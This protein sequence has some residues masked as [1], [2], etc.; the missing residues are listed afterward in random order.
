MTPEQLW[1]EFVDKYPSYK[2]KTYDVFAFGDKTD[3]LL[4]LVISGEKT[5]TSCIYR[6]GSTNQ[7]GDIGIILD[8]A[9]NAQ[10]IIEDTKVSIVPFNK[11]NA[12]FARKEGE[13]DKTLATWRKIHKAFWKDMKPDTLLECEE[14]KLLYP[15]K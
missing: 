12:A 6:G 14:F 3:E 10:A 15:T 13:G 11:V 5:A 8:S 9:G 2:G 4:Q 7:V 1:K